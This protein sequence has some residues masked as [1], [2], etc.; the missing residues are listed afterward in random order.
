M[1][2]PEQGGTADKPDPNP[3]PAPERG[4]WF[5][6][7]VLGAQRPTARGGRSVAPR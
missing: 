7:I 2:V 3:V 4:E 1:A 5:F 6:P